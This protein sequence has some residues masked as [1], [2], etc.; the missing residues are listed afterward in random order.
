MLERLRAEKRAS[1]V[2]D[3]SVVEYAFARLGL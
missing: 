2:V 3:A 1:L